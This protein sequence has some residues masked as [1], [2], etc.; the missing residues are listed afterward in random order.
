MD[1]VDPAYTSQ[2]CPVCGN[3]TKDNR[4]NHG[5]IFKCTNCEYTEHADIVGAIN[6]LLNGIVKDQEK[7]LEI[8]GLLVNQ[9]N[10]PQKLE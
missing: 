4:P 2:R 8:Q 5:E 10:V 7:Y 3:T 9:S 1:K 6:I